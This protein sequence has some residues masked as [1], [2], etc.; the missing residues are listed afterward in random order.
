LCQFETC[1]R[2]A[3]ATKDGTMTWVAGVDGCKAGWFVVLRQVTSGNTAYEVKATFVEL[4]NLPQSPETITIDIPIGFLEAAERG[5][6][7]CDRQA[8]SLLVGRRSSVFSPPVRS[9]LLHHGYTE[10]LL[11]N[12]RSSP[13]RIGI[14][15]QCFG[16]FEKLREVDAAM[17]RQVNLQ[18]KIREVHPEL[19]FM[20]IAGHPMKHPKRTDEGYT[21]RKKVLIEFRDIIGML[22]KER[23]RNVAKDDVLDGCAACWTAMRIESKP[24]Q[25][26]CIPVNPP[27]DSRGLRMEMWR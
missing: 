5:G 22:E 4:L 15:R 12:R 3:G 19:C 26:V 1:R 10:A 23:P 18:N 17:T 21:E 9:A 11:A 8:R 6:R 27:A 7:S 24:T 25:A 20:E 2:D 16:L 14:S 13:L